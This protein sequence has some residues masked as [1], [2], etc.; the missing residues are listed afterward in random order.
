MARRSLCLAVSLAWVGASSAQG[1]GLGAVSHPR[2]VLRDG[3]LA[4]ALGP[5]AQEA[6]LKASNTGDGDA[7]GTSIAISGD[8]MV[9]GAWNEDSDADGVNGN[10]ADNSAPQAGAAYVFVRSGGSWIQQ[11]YLKPLHSDANDQFG[12]SVAIDG[13]TIVVG[14][15]G[16]DSAAVDVGGDQTDNSRDASGAAYVF[17]RS[18][19]VWT[20]QA[21]LKA[22]NPGAFDLFGSS[23]AIH[24]DTVVVGAPLEDSDTNLIN[25]LGSDDSAP[26]AGAA[27]VFTRSGTIWSP[28]AY[29]K[30]FNSD[31]GDRFGSA[32]DVFEDSLIVGAERER[33]GVPSGAD[34]FDNSTSGAGAAYVF[35]RTLGV[36]STT[37]YLKPNFPNTDDHF[38]A[39]VAVDGKTFVVGAPREDGDS[40]SINSGEA[41]DSALRAGAVYVFFEDSGW[42]Q[43][44]Y[45]KAFNSD[46]EDLFGTS[47]ALHG[48]T[49]VVGARQ[50]A[51]SDTGI[52]ANHLDNSADQAGAVYTFERDA[53]TWSQ[54]AYVKPLVAQM[55]DRFGTAVGVSGQLVVATAVDEDSAAVGVNGDDTDDSSDA[56]GAAYAFDFAEPLPEAWTDEGCALPG[57]SG[58]PL[59][60]GSGTLAPGAPQS[61]DLFFA[62]PS[63]FM[64]IFASTTSTPVNF[65]GGML[66]PIPFVILK[67]ANTSPAG[68]LTLPFLTPV[69]LPAGLEIWVQMA[70]QDPAAILGVSLS[71]AVLGVTP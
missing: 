44:A 31:A 36:W 69:G 29:I 47:L 55:D 12:G 59:L 49:L 28:Q 68:G 2:D 23:V 61:L 22:S 58:N 37:G 45:I 53:G 34:A 67:F 41:D 57:I 7:F 11:A 9:V 25:G 17:T 63:A 33:S 48:D 10:P 62:A 14:S 20:Q 56:S 3:A 16:E 18:G 26:D 38:G 46:A 19:T 39:T 4:P 40:N 15:A 35:A 43:S 13:D 1:V 66:K 42:V 6:Y 32:V 60:V 52:G 5:G 27:Y 54:H 30:T 71:N 21:Y 51:S 8:T 50:E 70:I 65:K 24:G 64:G